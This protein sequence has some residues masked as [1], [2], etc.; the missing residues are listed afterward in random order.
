M[1][2]DNFMKNIIFRG[3][4]V[5]L[6]LLARVGTAQEPYPAPAPPPGQATAVQANLSP[7]AAEV[8][9]LAQSGVT[10]DVVLAYI[11]NSQATFNLAADD[12]VYLR[13]VGLSSPVITAMLNHDNTLR[14]QQPQYPPPSTPVPTEPP[15]TAPVEA[16]L[17]PPSE[18][19]YVG[20]PPPEVN[21]FY[22]DLSPYGAWVDLE[23]LGWCWQPRVVV[24]NHS[25][26]PYCDGGHWVYT[27]AGWYWQSDYSWGWAPFHYGR[28]Q[29]HP[30]C[31]WVWAPDTVWAPSWVVW[32]TSGDYCGWA[33]VPPHA[34][35]DAHAGWVF[36]GVRVGFEFDFGLRPDHFSFVHFHDFCERDIGIR[37]LHTTEVTRIY[38]RTTIINNY[39]VNNTTIVNRGIPV[40]RVA[41]VSH[42]PVP[43]ATVRTV[44]ETTVK[45][46]RAPQTAER[47]S[48]VVYRPERLAPARRAQTTIVA[49][50]VDAQHPVVH[51]DPVVHNTAIATPGGERS[52][53]PAGT[54]SRPVTP[55]G[56]R[57]PN[58]ITPRTAPER[59]SRQAAPAAPSAAPAN[60]NRTPAYQT[61]PLPRSSPSAPAPVGRTA[62]PT[63]QPAPTT[64][65]TTPQVAPLTPRESQTRSFEP[66][67]TSAREVPVTR[68]ESP[69]RREA[70]IT[71]T[72]P[73]P[74][75]QAPV[76]RPEPAPQRQVP[77]SR[78]EPA[79]QRQA[80]VSRPEP[81]LV[82]RSE[83]SRAPA[84]PQSSWAAPREAPAQNPHVYYPKTYH[85]S[86]DSRSRSQP[87]QRDVAPPPKAQAS[88]ATPSK[89][90]DF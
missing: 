51:H 20:N 86:I 59:P 18:P 71:R 87:P 7:G 30:R 60:P 41:A 74:Q 89:K 28:W 4:F 84:Q 48:P 58:P 66:P 79:P 62:T 34:F 22:D 78:P 16:P 29:M 61:T 33:P 5:A 26:R 15:S 69:S 53:V 65:R 36:N 52:R 8:V 73:A 64:P 9:R 10:E 88:P 27:D 17:V 90:N 44:A 70:P 11:Q 77:V 54:V 50:R 2:S 46:A 80:P 13:D 43:R 24:V 3:L 19:G 72:E 68:P 37:R 63:Y 23:G 55:H 45:S 40:D 38:N 6:G 25:W 21:Y 82:P 47:G 81:P 75:R 42:T 32:R 85:Q 49:Q 57:E 31:G 67:R 83:P 12:V 39:T 35:F 56:V 1:K 14:S 76:T